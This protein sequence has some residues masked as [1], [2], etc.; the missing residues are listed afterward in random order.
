[1]F[2]ET[3]Q[4][5]LEQAARLVN[6]VLAFE[7]ESDPVAPIGLVRSELPEAPERLLGGVE[8][9]SCELRSPE[10]L[11][12]ATEPAVTVGQ[13]RQQLDGTRAL[14]LLQLQLRQG[15]R[16]FYVFRALFEQRLELGLGFA[17]EVLV[18]Q[19]LGQEAPNAR[20]QYSFVARQ[21]REQLTQLCRWL[22]LE[23]VAQTKAS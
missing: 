1:M 23:A 14:A 11:I 20:A 21:V 6:L 18:A 8:L 7:R 10:Q 9:G 5:T 2:G 16:G 19:C 3:L 4:V 15:Q 22:C 17:D 13:R 12:G